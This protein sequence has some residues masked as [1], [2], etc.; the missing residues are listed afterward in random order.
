MAFS[1]DGDPT[2]HF[3]GWFDSIKEVAQ[4]VIPKNTIVGKALGGDYSGAAAG[5]IKLASGSGSKPT[6]SA[7]GAGA[8]SSGPS[9][10]GGFFEKN[11]T[12]LLLV[13][14]GLLAFLLL[15]RR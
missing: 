6:A 3:N 8:V 9:A 13:A 14:A 10:P 5:A 2:P 11:Q 12:V 15:R 1:Y 7:T 4:Q